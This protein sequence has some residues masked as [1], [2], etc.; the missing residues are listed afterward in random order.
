MLLVRSQQACLERL[1]SAIRWGRGL[2]LLIG[3]P[4]QGKSTLLKELNVNSVYLPLQLDGQVITDRRDAIFRLVASVGIQPEE[5]DLG[6]LNRLQA[7]Q[8][9]GVEKGVP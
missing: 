4:E 5:S 1:R 3:S 7:K 2:V 9:V 6:M 8:F